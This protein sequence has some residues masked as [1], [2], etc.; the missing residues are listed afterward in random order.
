MS[1]LLSIGDFAR[2]T[3]LSVKALRHYHDQGLLEPAQIDA[4]SGY[5]RYRLEQISIAQI[6]HRFR[7]LGMPLDDIRDVLHTDDLAA[8]NELIARHLR[9]LERELATTQSAVASLRDLLEHP[10]VQTPIEH[11]RIPERRVAAISGHVEI[12]DIGA[13]YQGALGELYAVLDSQQIDDPGTAAGIYADELFTDEHGQAT[14]YLPITSALRPAG[15]VHLTEL[16]AAELA[17]IA[18][19]G[20]D[21]GI[22]RSYGAL[23]TYVSRHALAV[24]GPIHEFYPVNRHHT[25]DRSRWRTEIGWPIFETQPPPS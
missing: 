14:L 12:A 21:D 1:E 18:H 20:P 4:A 22:D 23:A 8:R 9:R 15:R 3:H 5:R 6:I 13:W 25:A 17:V 11:R 7:G 10:R 2:A 24:D 16:P 19:D